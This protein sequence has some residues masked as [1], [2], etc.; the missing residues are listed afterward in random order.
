M[1]TPA[2]YIFKESRIENR[3]SNINGYPEPRAKDLGGGQG[4]CPARK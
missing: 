4:A 2:R 1:T 3:E